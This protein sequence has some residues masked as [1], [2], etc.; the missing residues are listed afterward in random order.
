MIILKI[1]SVTSFQRVSIDLS[2]QVDTM[3]N[4]CFTSFK[5]RLCDSEI[6][7]SCEYTEYFFRDGFY[8][9]EDIVSKWSPKRVRY[10]FPAV[11]CFWCPQRIGRFE[12][13]HGDYIQFFPSAL[14][15]EEKGISPNI[16]LPAEDVFDV[17][18]ISDSEEPQ[19]EICD[20][21][22][23]SDME[24]SLSEDEDDD[25]IFISYSK[26]FQ[27]D[28]DAMETIYISDSE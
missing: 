19:H 16:I 23:L 5:C 7:C 6:F 27:P 4:M 21:V 13:L 15:I 11:Y 25:V 17:T 22:Y 8:F 10:Q 9:R 18:Y 1:H 26:D 14:K 2:H 3:S 20:A 12:D 24:N 28:E